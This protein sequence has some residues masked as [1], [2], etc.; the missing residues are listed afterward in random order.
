MATPYTPLTND[1]D[2]ALRSRPEP[3]SRRLLRWLGHV[4]IW[5]APWPRGHAVVESELRRRCAFPQDAWRTRELDTDGVVKILAALA[6]LGAWPNANFL[7]DD[8]FL[9]V[10]RN[11]C[12]DWVPE[13]LMCKIESE[14]TNGVHV[15][16]LIQSALDEDW[17]VGKF[18]ECVLD[19]AGRSGMGN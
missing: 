15:D 11:S 4:Q 7:P 13:Q 9:F 18:V 14:L 10:V 5:L 16:D 17:S 3:W 8:S 1:L 12:V 2:E 6:D 19:R